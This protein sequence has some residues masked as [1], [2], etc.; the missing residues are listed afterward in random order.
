MQ[1]NPLEIVQKNWIWPYEQ[2]VYAQSSI[3]PGKWN[4]QAPLGFWDTNGSLN[5]GQTTRPYS[6]QQKRELAESWTLLFRVKLKESEKKD[7]YFDF[8]RELKKTVEHEN[9]DYCNWCSW[10]SHQRIDTR[11]GGLGNKRTRGDH[12]DYCI[13]E[14]GQNIKKSPGDL[15]RLA[16]T[17]TL[18][19]DH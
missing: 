2:M 8:A 1:G 19:K 18:V 14:I 3:C 4:A 11:T 16:V 5:L 17:Q 10:Y 6:N 9:D 7:K 15:R 12:P 13:I